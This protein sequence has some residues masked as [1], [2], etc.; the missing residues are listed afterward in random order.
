MP[1]SVALLLVLALAVVAYWIGLSGPLIFDDEQNLSPMREWLSGNQ[2]WQWVV[3]GNES[4]LLGRP[5]SMLSFVFNV[6]LLGDDIWML[7]LGNLLIHL[8]TSLVVYAVLWRLLF[9]GGALRSVHSTATWLPLAGA[10][11]W[12]LHPL[13]VSTV[14]YVIQRMAML[15]ALFALLAMLSY[16]NGRIALRRDSRRKALLWLLVGV[17]TFTTLAVFSKENGIL[18]PALCGLLEWLVFVPTAGKPRHRLSRVVIFSTLVLPLLIMIA[19]TLWGHPLIVEG[20]ANRPFS[21]WERLLTQS[22]VLWSYIGSLILPFGPKLG[23]YHDDYPISLGFFEPTSTAVAIV[24]WGLVIICSWRLREAAPGVALGVGVFLVGHSLESSVFPLLMYFEHRNYLPGVGLIWA[25]LSLLSW[26]SLHLGKHLNHGAGVARFAALALAL[27]FSVAT[28]ARAGVWQSTESIL[29]QG[30]Q[31][32]PDSRWLRLD[33]AKYM[34][35]KRPPDVESARMH[36]DAVMQF[37][38][39]AARRIAGIWRILVDC[40]VSDQPIQEYLGA[41][42]E[43]ELKLLE[44]DALVPL[45]ALIDGV[46]TTPCP[47]LPAAGLAA[48]LTRMADGTTL[49]SGNYNIRRLRFGAAKLYLKAG[50]PVDAL[51][52]AKKADSTT[53]LDAP[54]A[55]LVAELY[56]A[57]GQLEAASEVVQRAE[58]QSATS[59]VATKHYVE[60]LKQRL[61]AARA[62]RQSRSS[63]QIP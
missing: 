35:E 60:S 54:M 13:F 53:N 52:Q 57:A 29:A 63:S 36:I 48:R 21:L 9:A 39:P 46:R 11:I 4:G 33:I 5:I 44:A 30:L 40:S 19:L 38:E 15:S 26:V 20:Y 47:G 18:A 3:L 17:P 27:A 32:H 31:F 56:L 49:D 43:G 50:N 45:E 58:D 8:A 61:E 16:L 12:C 51:E 41:A 59:D 62:V 1:R 37:P 6:W 42:F 7:K 25:L 23:L 2:T 10:A 14:L 55:M 34:M 22:R 24:A 28:W